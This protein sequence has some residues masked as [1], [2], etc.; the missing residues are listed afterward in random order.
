MP[1]IRRSYITKCHP[2]DGGH[3]IYEA[4]QETKVA[5][6]QLYGAIESSSP[7][8]YTTQDSRDW[9]EWVYHTF[10][11]SQKYPYRSELSLQLIIKWSQLRILAAAT[12]PLILSFA[13][14]IYYMSMHEGV[15]STS[16]AW[17]IAR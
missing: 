14:G 5:L 15:E 8:K 1:L 7:D 13:V 17:T 4:S 12:L 10:N 3:S 11:D 6:S 2:I 16:A 9:A